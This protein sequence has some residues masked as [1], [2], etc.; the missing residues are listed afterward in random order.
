VSRHLFRILLSFFLLLAGLFPT[1]RSGRAQDTSPGN[2]YNL[3]TA[4][5]PSITVSADVFD[6][7]GKFLEGL[8][9]P[10]FIVL[11]DDLERPLDALEIVDPG[12]EFVVAINPGRSFAIL[13]NQAISRFAKIVSSLADWAGKLSVSS[14]DAYSLVTA[15]GSSAFHIKDPK[16]WLTS[17]QS[18]QPDIKNL[19]PSLDI[20]S[21]AIDIASASM[22]PPGARRAILFIT[23][24]PEATDLS[25]LQSLA[26]RANQLNVSIFVW[27]VASAD[28]PVSPAY[29]ALQDM[30]LQTGGQ[31]Q[32]Y[33]GSEILPSPADYLA[34]MRSTYQ[35]TYTSGLTA[36]GSHSLAVRVSTPAGQIDLPPLTFDMD[37]QPPNPILVSPP[38]EIIRQSLQPDSYDV[39]NLS[40]TQQK[41]ELIIE[42]PDGHSRP[43]GST[44]LVVDGQ[45]VAKNTSE[46]FDQFTWDLSGYTTSASHDLQVEAVDMLGLQK[47]SI[48]IPI[49][50]TITAAPRGLGVFLARYGN[51]IIL[52]AASLASL[53][54][55]WLLI[56]IGKRKRAARR[57]KKTA[58]QAPVQSEAEKQTGSDLKGKNSSAYLQP[59]LENEP[60]GDIGNFQLSSKETSVGSDATRS[61]LVLKD[62]SIAPLHAILRMQESHYYISDQGSTAGTWVNYEMLTNEPRRLKHGDIIHFGQ[63]TYRFL[64]SN[65]PERPGPHIVLDSPKP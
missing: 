40:P 24:I 22:L 29:L 1:P 15:G 44:S 23:P 32:V 60:S 62:P 35:L 61:L 39:N 5:F 57:L 16:S 17:L 53:L 58:S 64:L 18:Y 4:S 19:T 9:I 7:T 38:S 31:M 6:T 20:L 50:V 13:D 41:I 37:I 11:E 45:V 42:F 54:L 48:P 47:T 49:M 36:S 51:W 33:S 43:L 21:R 26:L 10:D 25:T 34:P 8:T 14:T 30:A 46:P 12:V 56:S 65:P 63:R 27:A 3:R 2:L 55:V 28:T 59:I 52:A